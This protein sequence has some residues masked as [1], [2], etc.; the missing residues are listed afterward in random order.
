MVRANEAGPESSVVRAVVDQSARVLETYRIDPGLIQE[1]ANGERRIFQGGY[2][3]RQIF[4]LVQNGA[5]EVRAQPG[6]EIRVVL[7]AERLYVANEGSPFTAEGV[8]TIL[9]MGVSNKRGGQIGRFGVG[10]KSVLSI[11]DSPEFHSRSGSFGFDR[12]WSAERIR[13]VHPGVEETPVLRMARVYDEGTAADS[14]PILAELLAW[15]T[16]V[17]RLPLKPGAV[18]RIARDLRAFPAEFALFAP[19]VGT[20]IVED[21]RAGG[22]YKRELFANRS[23]DRHT[24]QTSTPGQPDVTEAWRVFTRVHVPSQ[25]ARGQAGELHDR[26]EIDVSWAVPEQNL[27]KRGEFWAYF[28]TNYN[29]TLRGIVNAPWKTSEDR[30]NLFAGNQFNTELIEVAAE[31]ITDTLPALVDPEDP[32]SYLG[33]IPARGREAAQWADEALT[34]RVY[35]LAA[36]KPSLPD[37]DGVL[38]PPAEVNLHPRGLKDVWLELWAGCPGRPQDWCHHTVEH[39]ERRNRVEQ[40]RENAKVNTAS[41]REWLEALVADGSAESSARAVRILAAIHLNGGTVEESSKARQV[42]EDALKARVILT[43]EHGLVPPVLGKVYRRP[44]GERLAEKLVYVDP[45]VVASGYETERALD[46]LGVREADAAGRLESIVEQ[47]FDHYTD[48]QWTD[49]WEFTRLAGAQTTVGILERRGRLDAARIKVRTVSGRFRSADHC[50]LPGSVVPG[51]GSRDAEVAVDLGFH[52]ED[53]V[54]LGALG[55]G[56]APRL[57]VDP[58]G[59]GWFAQYIATAHEE[60]CK[61]LPTNA[62]RPHLSSMRLE[63]ANPA[64]PLSL[65][66]ELSEEGRAAF[67]RHLPPA[68]LVS[69]WTMRVGNAAGKSAI[70]SPLA[71]MVRKHGLVSTS[72]GVL[73]PADAVGPGLR[74]HDSVLPVAGIGEP[75]A[76]LLKLAD[77]LEAVPQRVWR[78]V[79]DEIARSTD[80]ELPGLAYALKLKAGPWYPDGVKTRCRIGDEWSTRPDDEIAVAVGRAE[81]DTLVREQIP[82]LLVSA[83]EDAERMVQAWGMRRLGDVIEREL[84]YAADADPSPLTEEF[85]YLRVRF[86]AR[87]AGWTVIRCSQLEHVVRTPL[88]LRSEVLDSAVE[89]QGVLVRAPED[90]LATL[91]AVDRELKLGLGR[92]GCQ[93]VLDQREKQRDDERIQRARRAQDQVDKLVALLDPDVLKRGLPEGL[94]ESDEAEHGGP[95]S[96]RR[97]A[98]LAVNAYGDGVLRQYKDD[99][100]K[101]FPDTMGDFRGSAKSRQFVADL[102]FNENF[103]GVK[104]IV[105]PEVE[106]VDGPSRYPALHAYQERIVEATVALLGRDVPGRAMLCLPT[107]AGKTRVAA[108]AV[109]RGL[110]SGDLDGPILWIAQTQELCEQAVQSWK[111]VWSK[112]GPERRLTISR[113]WTTNEATPVGNGPHLVVATDAKLEACLDT[114]AYAWLRK[115]AVVI[116]DE[117]HTSITPR[118]TGLLKSLGLT[119]SVT[120]RP[121]IGLTATPYRGV[122]EA[123]THRLVER[124]GRLRLD[125]GVFEDDPYRALQELGMLAQVEHELLAGAELTLDDDELRRMDFAG[126][127][128]ATA[129]QRLARN[130]ERNKVILERIAEFPEDWTTLLF[131]TSVDHARVLAARLND[132]GV[133]AASVDSATPPADRRARVEQFRSGRIRVLTNYGVLA[134]GFDAPATNAVVVA[135]PTYSP[136][137]YQQM[138]GRGLRGPKNGGEDTC[139]ILNVQDNITNYGTGLAFTTFEH[140]WSRK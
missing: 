95:T 81:Y 51:D 75:L 35:A 65:L 2:G 33:L 115:P 97:L 93:G 105:L 40:I 12:E 49:L 109:I 107:G 85:P 16:T 126:S 120:R 106:H 80:D 92:P 72:K 45:A 74:G 136:N 91:T 62:S 69:S 86:G 73:K 24:I 98:Q 47:G 70:L 113:L 77:S 129:E 4:E 78:S 82:A 132:R 17:V 99:L 23:G 30:Q 137:V 83:Q 84:R 134:Q 61:T 9:R 22:L 104:S 79:F 59:E 10:V 19:H 96:P 117:A 1:H 42:L 11:S 111:F 28:P 89:G 101:T 46:Q 6:G 53:H 67:V 140:L 138:I 116:V 124:Y 125:E 14:D 130:E 50:L 119:S 108:E 127:L 60:Y 54:L 66:L 20:V 114:E 110:R 128:P 36:A 21:R 27:N 88:G 18:D 94:V 8:Q 103:A 39:R 68:G 7:T 133:S 25:A 57:S 76:G 31:L 13:A 52:R 64:G 118:Y 55:L 38:Q 63:G 58:R 44:A 29:T 71:W 121:L 56:P 15:A 90:D 122:N 131:A 26:P 37:Q 41:V 3:D 32:G 48:R 135:R 139:L 100:A 123:E 43:E 102:G 5:D 87:V 112:V 34:R